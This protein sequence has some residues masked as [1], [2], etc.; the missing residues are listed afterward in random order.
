MLFFHENQIQILERFL[1]KGVFFK[2]FLFFG[3][4]GIGKKEV[5]LWFLRKISPVPLEK[6]PD[7]FEVI[8]E[9][10]AIK[11]SQ[12]QEISQRTS[13]KP[14]LTQAHLILIREAEKMTLEAQNCFLKTL[15]E[16]K[17][18]TVFVLITCAKERLL[19]TIISRCFLLKFS[20]P[21]PSKIEKFLIKMGVDE[22]KA[23]ELSFFC[24][25]KIELAKEIA[26]NNEKYENLR[27]L[28]QEFSLSLKSPFLKRFEFVEKICKEKK[29]LLSLN[30]GI[31][32]LRM[33]LYQKIQKKENFEKIKD[34]IEKLQ[35]LY[36]HFQTKN[37]NSKLALENFFLQV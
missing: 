13:F 21:P 24:Q 37:L 30:V 23:K 2:N 17:S 1:K 25:G 15:E 36:F 11:I 8:P 14:L 7:F 35:R 27:K 32:F 5:A 33:N 29:E 10:N 9:K 3:P 22:K 31:A 28:L 34:L 18:K 26:Q 6:N 19:P 12:I 16:P 4:E 20:P